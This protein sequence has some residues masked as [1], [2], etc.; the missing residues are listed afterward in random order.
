[1]NT[2]SAKVYVVP[3]DSDVMCGRGRVA[4]QHIGNLRLRAR[5][6]LN[7]E[8][9]NTCG[10]RTAKTEIIRR[11]IRSVS[12][13][14][15][16]FLK[17]DPTAEKWYDGGATA[18]KNR[19]G[20]AFRDASVPDK[21]KCM[22]AMKSHIKQTSLPPRPSTIVSFRPIEAQ[23]PTVQQFSSRQPFGV[24]SQN[25]SLTRQTVRQV[26]PVNLP[27]MVT[28]LGACFEPAPIDSDDEDFGSDHVQ[29]LLEALDC[30]DIECDSDS[31]TCCSDML[32]EIED[33]VDLLLKRTIELTIYL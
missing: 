8:Q 3:S 32:E 9:Y 20:S 28:S 11:I 2:I 23:T 24:L 15:G 30:S 4:F 33:D 25:P 7:L 10:S 1:M 14:R 31:E 18:A 21:V 5:I 27:Q 16:R 19:V 6:G 26:S 29:D 13:D 17:Y 12:M 22:E